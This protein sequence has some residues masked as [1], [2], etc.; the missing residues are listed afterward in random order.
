MRT[1]Y[2]VPRLGVGSAL[3]GLFAFTS[4][5]VSSAS[6]AQAALPT[7]TAVV[8]VPV[9][10]ALGIF[11][12]VLLIVIL[13]RCRPVRNRIHRWRVAIVQWIDAV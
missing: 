9:S 6:S 12:G 4:V 1:F 8:P 13:A 11:G 3:L 2:G 5:C 7:L 10:V